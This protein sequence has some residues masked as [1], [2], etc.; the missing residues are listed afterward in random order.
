MQ[1]VASFGIVAAVVG[2]AALAIALGVIIAAPILAVPFFILGFGAFL[3]W[4]GRK[5]ARPG[6]HDQYASRVPTTEE[7]AAD[8][9]RDSS[10]P[11]ATASG[12][13]ARHRADA[14]GV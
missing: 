4:R 2:I 9:V 12:T 13:A 10:V 11:D 1:H 3:V 7:T 5:R 8:P 14:P 6:L